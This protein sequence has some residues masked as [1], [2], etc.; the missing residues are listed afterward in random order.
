[1]SARNAK[2]LLMM[3]VLVTLLFFVHVPSGGFQAQHGPTTPVNDLTLRIALA[4]LLLSLAVGGITV[5]RPFLISRAGHLSP[6]LLHS[7]AASAIGIS[8]RC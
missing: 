5:F 8:L 6:I 4:A 7:P 1:M 2:L 3:I